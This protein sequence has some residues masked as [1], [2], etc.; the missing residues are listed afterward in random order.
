[1]KTKIFNLIVLMLALSAA[2][3]Y[4]QQAEGGYIVK[5]ANSVGYRI[6][7]VTVLS[8]YANIEYKE[9][10]LIL[11]RNDGTKAIA[12]AHDGKIKTDFLKCKSVYLNQ[13][14]VLFYNGEKND[15]LIS[16]YTWQP[17]TT[18]QLSPDAG[19]YAPVTTA[20][21]S[22]FDNVSSAAAAQE[23]SN[24]STNNNSQQT[25]Y[26]VITEK[27]TP[28]QTAEKT[29]IKNESAVETTVKQYKGEPTIV[30]IDG[31]DYILFS[32]KEVFG[33]EKIT[34]LTK[35]FTDEKWFF[36]VK[37]DNAYGVV[38]VK[39]D[40]PSRLGGI[41]IGLKYYK[42][43]L[44]NNGYRVVNCS[45]PDGTVVQRWWDG[46]TLDEMPLK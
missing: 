42:V 28:T 32:E 26:I 24:R 40:M 33:A 19:N 2:S 23:I 1:M 16:T 21:K 6:N 34:A 5:D 44:A 13:G 36:I 14:T 30:R 4:A 37:A 22:F 38:W 41:S 20:Q 11:S 9:G 10:F 25:E 45:L 12:N 39:K 17:V 3:I 18:L 15:I 46:K 35:D 8:G 43:E 31:K 29:L 27:S 7:G